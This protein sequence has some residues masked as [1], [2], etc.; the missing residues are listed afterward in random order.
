MQV[1]K[2]ARPTEILKQVLQ[3]KDT[4]LRIAMKLRV[5]EMFQD[6]PDWFSSCTSFNPGLES[7]PV[8]ICNCICRLSDFLTCGL[9][10]QWRESCRKGDSLW[11]SN[12]AHWSEVWNQTQGPGAADVQ[13]NSSQFIGVL[14]WSFCRSAGNSWIPKP[15]LWAS[16][17]P[18]MKWIKS[19]CGHVGRVGTN[20]VC[21]GVKC[22]EQHP[23]CS[24]QDAHFYSTPI[25]L[26]HEG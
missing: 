2:P 5:F 4:E 14:A 22:A 11:P 7:F 1:G 19:G 10:P 25:L 9:W 23:T 13:E 3:I 8:E 16:L 17:L 18:S 26:W 6:C 20:W 15:L 21:E 12:T 24:G